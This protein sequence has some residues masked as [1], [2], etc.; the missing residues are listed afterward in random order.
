MSVPNGASLKW[1]FYIGIVA[2]MLFLGVRMGG[3]RL[4]TVLSNAP[5]IGKYFGYTVEEQV[6]R[7]GAAARSRLIPV[8]S[9][10]HLKYPPDHVEFIAIKSTKELLIYAATGQ[11]PYQY[12]CTYPILGASGI[13]GPKLREGDRQVPEGIYKLSLEPNTLY[14]LA[15]RLNYPNEQD[16]AHAHSDGRANPGFDILIHGTTGSVGCL[17]MGDPAS[18]DLFVLVNDSADR[19]SEVVIVPVDLRK[20]SPPPLAGNPPSWLPQLYERLK[21]KLSEY[22]VPQTSH[23]KK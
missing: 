11:S 2:T 12:V 3:H 5:V 14:H 18:E 4:R 6:D 1:I 22:P 7:Y 13:L 10:R 9:A 15:L 23:D 8:F 16:L 20:Q 19:R 21:E 17:A